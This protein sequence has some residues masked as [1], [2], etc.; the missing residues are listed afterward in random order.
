[1]A[2]VNLNNSIRSAEVIKATATRRQNVKTFRILTA[3][4]SNI[5]AAE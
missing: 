5:R 2:R 3:R 1:M 4:H